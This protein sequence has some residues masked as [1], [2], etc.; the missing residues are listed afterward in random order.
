MERIK[1]IHKGK[2][3]WI[4]GSGGSLL[5][6][7]EKKIPKEDIIICCNS[8]VSYFKKFHYAVFTDGSANYSNWYIKLKGKRNITFILLNNEIDSISKKTIR[9]EKDFQKWKFTKEDTKIIGGYDVIHCAAHI[10][11]MMGADEIILVGVDLKH[12]SRFQKHA[13]DQSLIDNAPEGLKQTVRESTA[14][15]ETL[16]DGHLGMSLSGWETIKTHNNLKI[17]SIGVNGNLN[18]F[19]LISFEN[20]INELR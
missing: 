5:D 17:R 12:V 4:C 6:V 3:F 18:I 9:L 13:N 1:S 8:A 16:F 7:D 2:R 10:A 20:L 14:S 19:P 15:N 11:F